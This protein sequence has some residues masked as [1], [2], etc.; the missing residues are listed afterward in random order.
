VGE[1]GFVEQIILQDIAPVIYAINGIIP[2]CVIFLATLVIV[3]TKHFKL[4]AFLAP[5]GD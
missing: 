3:G 4:I 1:C 2:L 5:F